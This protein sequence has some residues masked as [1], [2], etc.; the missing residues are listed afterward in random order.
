MRIDTSLTLSIHVHGP[1]LQF[2]Q[3]E[4]AMAMIDQEEWA[5]DNLSIK[6][7]GLDLPE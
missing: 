2:T 1:Y 3:S 5:R 7:G 4:E 6:M